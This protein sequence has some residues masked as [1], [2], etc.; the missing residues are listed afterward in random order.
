[1]VRQYAGD[2]L[3]LLIFVETYFVPYVVDFF[4]EGSMVCCE[5]YILCC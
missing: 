4:E 3:N 5:E 1:V 2:Y